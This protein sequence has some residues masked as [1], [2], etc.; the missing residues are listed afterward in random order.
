MG[1]NRFQ[2]GCV[3]VEY[4]LFNATTF[5]QNLTYVRFGKILVSFW[6]SFM[7]I[8]RDRNNV[9]KVSFKTWD[10][11]ILSYTPFHFSFTV[12]LKLLCLKGTGS[13]ISIDSP[14]KDDNV[15]FTILYPLNKTLYKTTQMPFYVYLEKNEYFMS[16]EGFKNS[17][18]NIYFLRLLINKS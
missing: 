10:S 1:Y 12:P 3:I 18:V 9:L 15:R 2:I 17:S 5:I 6:H 11:Q 14:C 7:S 4:D 16:K 13:V 8:S